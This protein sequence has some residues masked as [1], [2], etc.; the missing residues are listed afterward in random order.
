MADVIVTKEAHRYVARID[1]IDAEAE[2][3][4][5]S[6]APGTLVAVHTGVPDAFRG[7]GVGRV[8]VTRLVEDARKDGFKI[9]PACSFVDAERRKH[10]EWAD[11]FVS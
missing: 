9:V 6:G 5:R 11:A 3:T 8:L 7:K 2:L 10:P 4:F 1:G